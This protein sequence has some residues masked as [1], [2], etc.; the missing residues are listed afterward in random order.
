MQQTEKN[1][2]SILDSIAKELFVFL[3]NIKINSEENHKI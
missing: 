1:I 3:E 2:Y